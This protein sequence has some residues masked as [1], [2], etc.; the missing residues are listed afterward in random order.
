MMRLVHHNFFRISPNIMDSAL[1]QIA[2]KCAS[3][4]RAYRII[5]GVKRL[6]RKL[7]SGEFERVGT[8]MSER[9]TGPVGLF[10][11][12][13]NHLENEETDVVLRY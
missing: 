9:T 12:E 4:L 1:D 10:R 2:E 8:K 5:P 13:V 3:E 6:I 11:G 7:C